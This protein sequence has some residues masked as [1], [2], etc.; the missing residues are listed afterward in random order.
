MESKDIIKLFWKV[1]VQ[2]GVNLF[3][4]SLQLNDFKISWGI[5]RERFHVK[6]KQKKTEQKQKQTKKKEKKNISVMLRNQSTYIVLNINL[7]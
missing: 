2:L 1:T 6:K 4:I 3:V 5:R 7:I